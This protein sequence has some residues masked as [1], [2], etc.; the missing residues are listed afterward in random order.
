M[1][2]FTQKEKQVLMPLV[3]DTVNYGF[4]EKE[5]LAYI[6]ARLGRPISP[7]TYYR[8]KKEVDSGEYA[9]QW[10]SYF[11]R[12]GFVIKHQ[13]I[14]EV[15]E[16]VQKDTIRD[17]LIEQNKQPAERRNLDLIQK[18][19]YEIRENAKLLQ[20]LSLGTPVIAQIKAKLEHAAS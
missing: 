3:A 5:A 14:I 10:M 20:E 16:M 18:L 7:H 17:Y 9:N 12:V 11:S 13:Q 19:R 4:T 6:K 1:G 15:V 2:N 8:R